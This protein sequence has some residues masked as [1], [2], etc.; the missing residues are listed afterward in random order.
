VLL[1]ALEAP[2]ES[3][4][5]HHSWPAGYFDL[6]SAVGSE[7][8]DRLSRLYSRWQRDSTGVHA[9]SAMVGALTKLRSKAML[10]PYETPEGT[11][12]VA[13]GI[14]AL[15]QARTQARASLRRG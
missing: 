11:Q 10:A 9:G 7:H 2:D 15:R 6:A 1:D 4:I 12:M 8:L 13:A 14:A 3:D 5:S